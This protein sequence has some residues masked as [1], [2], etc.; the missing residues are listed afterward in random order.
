MVKRLLAVALAAWM[1]GQPAAAQ[2]QGST[3]ELLNRAQ[4][5][6]D[7]R[8]VEELVEKLKARE[9]PPSTPAPP[10]APAAAPAPAPKSAAPASAPPPLPSAALPPVKAQPDA[11]P[12]P[13]RS[14]SPEAD[15]PPPAATPSQPPVAA[16]ETPASP[17]P[18]VPPVARVPAPQP[19]SAAPARPDSMPPP[20]GTP[21]AAGAP[22]TAERLDLPRVDIEVFFGLDSADISPVSIERLAQLGR[23]LTDPRLRG[24]KFIIAGH[25]DAFGPPD[26]NLALSHRRAEAVRRFLIERFSLEADA[27]VARGYG[28]QTPKVRRNPFAPENRRVQIINWTVPASSEQR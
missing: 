24:S 5:E 22:E 26:Y 4:S 18:T 10:P 6:A 12:L 16:Q 21:P 9:A 14:Q 8:A 20:Q 2:A 17:P 25:T 1:V 27:L 28:S 3:K 23:A 7:K 15:A 13:G 19:D 11:P